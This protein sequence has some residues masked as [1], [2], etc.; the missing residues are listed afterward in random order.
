VRTNLSADQDPETRQLARLAY[1]FCRAAARP[2]EGGALPHL[3][4][5]DVIDMMWDDNQ[6]DL[7]RLWARVNA[8]LPEERHCILNPTIIDALPRESLSIAEI[9]VGT[10]RRNVT[11]HFLRKVV[12][13]MVP[14]KTSG[15][16]LAHGVPNLA[17]VFYK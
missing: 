5:K 8:V 11:D 2:I 12:P 17:N 3:K 9:F 10:L 1:V 14:A 13:P 16:F 15:Q 6:M 7:V 4:L